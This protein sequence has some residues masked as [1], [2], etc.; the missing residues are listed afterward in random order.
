MDAWDS[1]LQ[2][3]AEPAAQSRQPVPTAP[4]EVLCI[5]ACL[6]D[7]PGCDPKGGWCDFDVVHAIVD[8]PCILQCLLDETGRFAL[9]RAKPST[10]GLCQLPLPC[11]LSVMTV[12]SKGQLPEALQVLRGSMQDCVVGIDLEWCPDFVKGA[13]SQVALLQ[14]A[15]AT[16]CLLVRTS[17]VGMPP[18]LL[19]F[20]RDP[21]ICLLGFGWGGNDEKKMQHSFGI[22]KATFGYF[23][24]LKTVSEALGYYQYGVNTLASQL[25]SLRSP[26]GKQVTMSNWEAK[27]LSRRQVCYAAL[28][29]FLPGHIFRRAA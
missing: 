27:W 16:C 28:D 21:T 26:M 19:A 15:S 1:L 18:E 29:A 25:L 5:P 23:L 13:C 14:L 17:H 10:P 2:S 8:W 9:P 11:G 3:T 6:S 4:L 24:D 12:D 7:Q 20:L 22:G